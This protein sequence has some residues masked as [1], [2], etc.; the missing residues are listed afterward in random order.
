MYDGLQRDG[1]PT[2]QHFKQKAIA[3]TAAPE[4]KREVFSVSVLSSL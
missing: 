2:P 4:H 3:R 1:S